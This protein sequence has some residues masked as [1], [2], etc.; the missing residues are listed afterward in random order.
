M[1]ENQPMVWLG[2]GTNVIKA[3]H[4]CTE[5]YREKL[6]GRAKMG[7]ETRGQWDW[8]AEMCLPAVQVRICGDDDYVVCLPPLGYLGAH[9]GGK[10]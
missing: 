7:C 1:P 2:D 6:G 3:G 8:E 10:N 4:R 9:C 5:T